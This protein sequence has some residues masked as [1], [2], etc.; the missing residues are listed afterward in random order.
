MSAL[1]TVAGNSFNGKPQK[2]DF[3]IGYFMLPL[4][5]LTLE[6]WSFSILDFG[7]LDF[8]GEIWTKSYGTNFTKFWAFRQKMV[9]H[10]W[11]SVDAIL[12]G[13]SVTQTIVWR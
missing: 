8:A 6:V 3:P 13:V 10:F 2:N 9:N 5:M 4:P 7:P 11:Q 1:A 12:E